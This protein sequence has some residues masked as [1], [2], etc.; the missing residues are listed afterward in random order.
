MKKV[1]FFGALVMMFPLMSEA[2][3]GGIKDRLLEKTKLAAQKAA[4]DRSNEAVDTERD[5]LDSIDF[6]YA[7]SVIDNSGMLN[8]KD[9]TER[10]VTTVSAGKSFVQ[11]DSKKTP[12]Q[13]S[14]DKLDLAEKLYE[15]RKNSGPAEFTFLDS[16]LSYETEGIT[17]NINYSKVASD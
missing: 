15:E 1:I 10:A 2:Q 7:I 4:K 8:V 16:K 3:L 5:R 12:A 11:D 13:R 17:N 14:R 6:N 9:F